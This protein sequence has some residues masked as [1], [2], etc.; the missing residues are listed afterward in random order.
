MNCGYA[1]GAVDDAVAADAVVVVVVLVLVLDFA[2]VLLAM[3]VCVVTA[4]V[5]VAAPDVVEAMVLPE[6][7]LVVV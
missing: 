7:V 6:V 1:I 2:V 5:E 3:V 4:D